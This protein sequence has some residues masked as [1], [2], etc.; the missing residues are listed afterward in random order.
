MDVKEL[1]ARLNSCDKSTDLCQYL[2]TL[3]GEYLTAMC[4]RSSIDLDELSIICRILH[5][6]ARK[7]TPERAFICGMYAAKFERLKED[8]VDMKCEEKILEV[9]SDNENQKLFKFLFESGCCDYKDIQVEFSNKDLLDRLG[10]LVG[11][12]L[13]YCVELPTVTYFELTAKGYVYFNKTIGR[14]GN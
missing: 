5:K 1:V 14:W 9:L 10:R 12:D 2:G 3:Y 8:I 13:A 7:V 6:H 11:V 4:R